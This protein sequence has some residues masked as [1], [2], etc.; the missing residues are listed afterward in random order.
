M[1]EELFFNTGPALKFI[2]QLGIEPKDEYFYEFTEEDYNKLKTQGVDVKET[3]YMFIPDGYKYQASN[4]VQVAS[5][6][7]K[8]SIMSAAKTIEIYCEKSK[9]TFNLYEDKLKYAA[10][11]LPAVFS[12]GTRFSKYKKLKS[13]NNLD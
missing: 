10:S 9:L 3:M 7:G 2:F 13:I 8:N 1:L 12:E 11:R 4:E 6:S 5:E